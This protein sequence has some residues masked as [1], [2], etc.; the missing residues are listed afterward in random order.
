[1]IERVYERASQSN[2]DRVVVA[3]DDER[4]VAEVKKFG[5]EVIL[6][7]LDH[8]S[9]SDRIYEAAKIMGLGEQ[10]VV[11]NV[12]GDEPFVPPSLINDVAKEINH[13]T[14]VATLC[15]RIDSLDMLLNR[16][17]VK[18]VRDAFNNALYFSRAPIPFPPENVS[19]ENFVEQEQKYYRHIGIYAYTVRQLKKFVSQPPCSIEQVEKLEQLRMLNFGT[20]VRVEESEILSP[21]GVDTIEDVRR[22]I[23]EL[24]KD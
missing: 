3:T 1:M 17:I 11:V 20:K 4:I 9:G 15:E 23:S 6:T 16:N 12:Q 24:G 13:E 8:A 21:A 5:G 22:I 18:V 14:Q 2:A 7:S 10:E 19:N